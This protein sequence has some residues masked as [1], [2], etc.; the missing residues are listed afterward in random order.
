MKTLSNIQKQV[1][2]YAS[3]S[4]LI[5]TN[6]SNAKIQGI[7][8]ANRV[9]R[10]LANLN[11][12]PELTREDFSLSTVA[13]TSSYNFPASPKFSNVLKIEMENEFGDYEN[14]PEVKSR[15][16]WNYFSKQEG[17]LP[18]VYDLRSI[19]SQYTIYFAP[20]PK[21][22]K[23]VKITGV[24]EPDDFTSGDS[25]TIFY[26]SLLDDA[27]EYL[28]ASEILFTDGLSQEAVLLVQKASSLLTKYSGKEIRPDEID[29]RA[30]EAA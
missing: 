15:L 30:K 25:T 3:D 26:S 20:T 10:K 19:G 7:S 9:Y 16:D 18:S 22:S 27:L 28:I 21:I 2:I 6:D 12:W 11:S 4:T 8:I 17:V 23:T 14:I 5:I 29:P 24:V 13:N 1:R